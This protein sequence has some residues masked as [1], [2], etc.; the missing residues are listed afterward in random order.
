MVCGNLQSIP[1]FPPNDALCLCFVSKIL[2][3]FTKYVL[4]ALSNFNPFRILFY[5]KLLHKIQFYAIC[6][7]SLQNCYFCGIHFVCVKMYVIFNVLHMGALSN[8]FCSQM[9]LIYFVCCIFDSNPLWFCL[10]LYSF[11]YIMYFVGI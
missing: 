2:I 9:F 10:Q 1:N 8:V 5:V 6:A 4:L 11:A 3:F 7:F